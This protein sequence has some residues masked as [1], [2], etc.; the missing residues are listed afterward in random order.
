MR[1]ET[2]PNGLRVLLQE[3]RRAPVVSVQAWMQVGSA[4]EAGP[5]AGLSHMLEHMLFK[6]TSERGVGTI[7]RDIEGCGGEI[8]AYTSFDQTVL[9]LTVPSRHLRRGLDVARD[10]VV[11]PALDPEEFA[12]EKE[13][14]LE[15]IRRGEDDP[16]QRLSKAVFAEAYG[17]HPYGRPVIGTMESVR[18]FTPELL[19]DFHSRWYCPRN[20]TLVVTGDAD[21]DV[22][23]RVVEERFGDWMDTPV[24]AR[25]RTPEP[26]HDGL[27]VRV[28]AEAVVEARVELIFPLPAVDH[29]DIPV[30]DVMAV[31]LGQGESSRLNQEIRLKQQLA[32]HVHAFSYTP[33]DPGM[34]LVG[35]LAPPGAVEPLIGALA[36][37][38]GRMAR[39]GVAPEEVQRATIN[40]LSDRVYER[41]TVEGI[42]RKL[43]YFESLF[44]DPAAEARY[45]AGVTDV[46][47]SDVRRFAAETLALGRAAAGVMVPTDQ[48]ITAAQV[49]RGLGDGLGP[50]SSIPAE[51]A[52]GP[53]TERR[54]LPGGM[55]LV[56]RE[57][58]GNNLVSLRL[59]I[60]GGLLEES[61]RNNGV[62]NLLAR[63][64]PRG[65]GR[66]SAVEVAEAMDEIA[67]RVSSF[68]G[69]NSLGLSATFLA[70]GLRRG[71]D[72]FREVLLEPA[73]DPAE[74]D[75]MRALTIEGIR[76][77]PD[78]PISM[79]FLHFHRA[80][81]PGH[82]FRLP[83]MGTEASVRRLT[84]G[85]LRATYRR[86]LRRQGSV[87]VAV[88][89]FDGARMTERLSSI[90]ASLPPAGDK[91]LR[92]PPV[93]PLTTVR[94]RSVGV[95]KEQA[96]L[97]VGFPGVTVVDPDRHALE[98][99]AAI[100]A[101]QSGRLFLDLR[102][103]QGLAYSVT[104][105]SQEAVAPG[106]FA[107]YIGTERSKLDR[108]R[109]GIHTHLRRLRDEPVPDDELQRAVQ[110]LVGN[111][112]IGLQR[113]GAVASRML[114]DELYGLG[115]DS[116]ATYADR[117][118]SLTAA[119]LQRVAQ[120][121]LDLDR[122]V[123]LTLVPKKG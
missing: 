95:D 5:E 1:R 20:A 78:N 12:M 84:P 11:R 51:R 38:L 18:A 110:Y 119:D 116:M 29:P 15:E 87:V 33:R 90:L 109:D 52:V 2:L 50:A 34:L 45:Y 42:A 105:W 103:R 118:L 89:D 77:I 102:D 107:V 98:V 92:D 106:F 7:A 17:V 8:N 47:A 76:S 9:H 16:G 27:R 108:A 60:R 85:S 19:R 49:E 53:H 22:M 10:A 72:L 112:E 121:R 36:G 88:G 4:D 80:L 59:G 67:G 120:D 74:I 23:L 81:Y 31:I 43:G 6:G 91:T 66:R 21:S 113:G 30:A 75:R 82:P 111:F 48:P 71:L 62:H 83:V 86:G 3:V 93:L 32:N 40:I 117:L 44:G 99:L 65:T 115:H 69:R 41:E 46:T 58:P 79:A 26:L 97:V 25:E 123:E 55:T 68:S 70:S 100:L 14:V 57:N 73:F 54:E 56:V 24:P 122:H 104:A 39:D 94:R 114:F 64:W 63:S 35:A 101:G 96:H 13:V 61:P 28:M 37:E